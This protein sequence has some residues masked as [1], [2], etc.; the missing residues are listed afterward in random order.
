MTLE[1][2]ITGTPTHLRIVD[3]AIEVTLYFSSG[4]VI[5]PETYPDR[6]AALV[7]ARDYLICQASRAERAG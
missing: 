2:T 6:V 5:L 7:A 3:N 4:S 1:F